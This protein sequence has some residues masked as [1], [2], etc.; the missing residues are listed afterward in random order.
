MNRDH[1][2]QVVAAVRNDVLVQ[3]VPE[4]DMSLCSASD[5]SAKQADRKDRLARA[6][7]L[8]DRFILRQI[9]TDPFETPEQAIKALAPIAVWF[10]GYIAR[11]FAIMVIRAVW[12]SWLKRVEQK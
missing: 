6:N 7:R 3:V 2:I 11:Q 10:I 8:I 12:E 9:S 5:R 4:E 1:L